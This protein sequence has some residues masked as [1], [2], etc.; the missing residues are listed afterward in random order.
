VVVPARD[1]VAET[2]KKKN[3]RLIRALVVGADNRT[4]TSKTVALAW[5]YAVVFALLA[6]IIAKWFGSNAG[7]QA[8]LKHGLGDDYWLLLGG[9]YAAVIIAKASTSAQAQSGGKSS[10]AV[11]GAS[12]AQLVANDQGQADLG[13]FQYVVFNVVALVFFFAALIPHLSAGIPQ[14]PSFLIGLATVSAATYSAKKTLLQE[15]DPTLT[16]LAPSTALRSLASKATQ[17][18]VWGKNLIVKAPLGDGLD[19]T[20]A[21]LVAGVEAK[22]VASEKR[23]NADRLTVE[24]PASVPAGQVKVTAVR[25]DG[26]AASAPAD[27]DGLP[28]TLTDPLGAPTLTSLCP[29]A[30]PRGRAKVTIEVWGHGLIMPAAATHPLGHEMEPTVLIAGQEATVK[31][32]VSAY[33]SDRL[34]VEVPSATPVGATL[35]TAVRADGVAAVTSDG[36]DGLALTLTIGDPIVTRVLLEIEAGVAHVEVWGRDLIMTDTTTTHLPTVLVDGMGISVIDSDQASGADHLTVAAP[37]PL[38][39]EDATLTVVRADGAVGQMLWTKER[40]PAAV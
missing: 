33:G 38:P 4:S 37:D 18:E 5:T 6:L 12:P 10:A 26:V 27:Q 23:S 2:C 28:L 32:F 30:V 17:I 24:V 22:L 16:S 3:L 35:L 29:S 19:R 1:A 39:G 21:V 8:L 25:D 11:G 9:P 15:P 40:E 14:L 34:T 20:P 7:Y 36:S 13:D 31:T